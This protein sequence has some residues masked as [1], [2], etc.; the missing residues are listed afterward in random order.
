MF[1]SYICSMSENC[2]VCNT[3]ITDKYCSN[4]GQQFT[5]K[6]ATI[7]S[8]VLDFFSNF[9]SVEKSFIGTSRKLITNPKFIVENFLNGN[10]KYYISPG[11]FVLYG[12]TIL[13]LHSLIIGPT[14]WG[15]I[16]MYDGIQVQ[17]LFWMFLLPFLFLCSYLTFIR[18]GF[19][20]SKHI[21]SNSYFSTLFLFIFIIIDD[22]VITLFEGFNSAIPFLLFLIFVFLWNSFSFSK[23]GKISSHILNTIIQLLLFVGIF[24]LLMLFFQTDTTAD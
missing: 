4:C 14:I 8:L 23:K 6:K 19:N 12:I 18:Q 21:I 7:F 20:I 1:F 5:N 13:A 15:V 22:I 24:F 17:Y 3:P 10:K 11:S 9:F 2:S 16:L